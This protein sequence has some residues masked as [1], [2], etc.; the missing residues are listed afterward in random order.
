MARALLLC[1]ALCAPTLAMWTCSHG[2]F[3]HDWIVFNSYADDAQMNYL[4]KVADELKTKPY[5]DLADNCLSMVA[6]LTIG[7]HDDHGAFN[8]MDMD[9]HI[10]K[11]LGCEQ[12]IYIPI[13]DRY[14]RAAA[15]SICLMYGN[16]DYRG[17]GINSVGRFFEGLVRGA[18][19]RADKCS[20]AQSFTTLVSTAKQS[21]LICW[22]FVRD[23]RDLL[24]NL[25]RYDE[26][27]AGRDS[28]K[29]THPDMLAIYGAPKVDWKEVIDTEAVTQPVFLK[30]VEEMSPEE[31]CAADFGTKYPYYYEPSAMQAHDAANREEN[32]ELGTDGLKDI[33]KS[34]IKVQVKSS[35]DGRAPNYK[36]AVILEGAEDDVCVPEKPYTEVW[37]DKE[38]PEEYVR[39][40]RACAPP[41]TIGQRAVLRQV[42]MMSAVD[43]HDRP[44]VPTNAT[45]TRARGSGGASS[46]SASKTS[47]MSTVYSTAKGYWASGYSEKSLMASAMWLE[48]KLGDFGT[49]IGAPLRLLAKVTSVLKHMCAR[50]LLA[51]AKQFGVCPA[52]LTDSDCICKVVEPL[53]AAMDDVWKQPP[54][55]QGE[56]RAVTL[57]LAVGGDAH[58]PFGLYSGSAGAG[59]YV[60][61]YWKIKGESKFGLE[62]GGFAGHTRQYAIGTGHVSAGVAFFVELGVFFGLKSEQSEY[63]KGIDFGADLGV[64]GSIGLELWFRDT[65]VGVDNFEYCRPLD[66]GLNDESWVSPATA[67]NLLFPVNPV[68]IRGFAV[69]VHFGL[70]TF[71]FADF[72][73]YT[74]LSRTKQMTFLTW[75]AESNVGKEI[76]AKSQSIIDADKEEKRRKAE[77]KRLREEAEAKRK[78]EEAER[79]RLAEVQKH[80]AER[81]KLRQIER[82]R[83]AEAARQ[84][85][86]ERVRREREIQA[87]AERR[88]REEEAELT[89]SL[90]QGKLNWYARRSRE[91]KAGILKKLPHGMT[92]YVTGFQDKLFVQKG[93]TLVYYKRWTTVDEKSYTPLDDPEKGTMDLSRAIMIVDDDVTDAEKMKRPT[94]EMLTFQIVAP[95]IETGESLDLT[96]RTKSAQEFRSWVL[97]LDNKISIAKVKG[98]DGWA[99]DHA[100]FWLTEVDG[101]EQLRS[102]I[103]G[104]DCQFQLPPRSDLEEIP[105]GFTKSFDMLDQIERDLEELD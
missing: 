66:Y 101:G 53:I 103:A 87:E 76:A 18:G 11:K 77:E 97:L 21:N 1:L 34:A 52:H 37:G 63:G 15:M 44:E 49:Y 32:R 70:G 45:N 31:V 60:T 20:S 27:P 54:P 94:V 25:V 46:G 73:V 17:Y 9:D 8:G 59:I 91:A 6:G 95:L 82:E 28:G 99:D 75:E 2:N 72:N 80:E 78:R 39:I 105:Y 41:A 35:T 85:E 58:L 33:K 93:S 71:K 74:S 19:D 3:Q 62:I 40:R 36:P 29:K 68:C 22:E 50:A 23:V 86:I 96:I 5:G 89:R 38:V 13:H 83:L 61:L 90:T 26:T 88:K 81:E 55:M 43:N 69:S 12:A 92:A 100:H 48:A 57:S 98:Y 56:T 14:A 16:S 42:P 104:Y 64:E 65:Y 24:C 102:S 4:L 7:W 30:P 67:R 47:A 10:T 84:K 51:A 79:I